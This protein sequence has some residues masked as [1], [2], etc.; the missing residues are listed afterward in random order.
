MQGT[1]TYVAYRLCP[2]AIFKSLH[3]NCL[4]FDQFCRPLINTIIICLCDLHLFTFIAATIKKLTLLCRK[5]MLGILLLPRQSRKY[6]TEGLNYL[7]KPPSSKLK[8]KLRKLPK[9]I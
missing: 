2:N 5:Q 9:I 4:M 6:L 7:K 3:T 1:K 8:I